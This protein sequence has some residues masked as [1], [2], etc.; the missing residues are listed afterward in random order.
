M[1]LAL[2]S[3]LKSKKPRNANRRERAVC[4]IFTGEEGAKGRVVVAFR[5]KVAKEQLAETEQVW[6]WRGQ[7]KNK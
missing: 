6:T 1:A 7:W 4:M 3:Q 2:P 5:G